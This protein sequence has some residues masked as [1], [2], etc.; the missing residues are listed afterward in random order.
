MLHFHAILNQLKDLQEAGQLAF[1]QDNSTKIV[2][3][4]KLFG[5]V[6][7]TAAA[8]FAVMVEGAL[9]EKAN[10]INIAKVVLNTVN[11][12]GESAQAIMYSPSG[13]DVPVYIKDNTD[14]TYLITHKP[15]ETG[16]H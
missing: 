9:R 7:S 15:S 8:G 1:F 13:L 16:P 12:G 11:Y 2:N 5:Q 4:I 14:G 3:D 6:S 10:E